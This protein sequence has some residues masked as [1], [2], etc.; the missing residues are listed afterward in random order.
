MKYAV[1]PNSCCEP[2]PALVATFG[3]PAACSAAALQDKEDD[4]KANG[5]VGTGR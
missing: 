2:V 5:N 3:A 4:Q 1:K